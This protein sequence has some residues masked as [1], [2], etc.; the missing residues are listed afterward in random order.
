MEQQ[1]AEKPRTIEEAFSLLEK[2]S[3]VEINTL[4]AI[5]ILQNTQ[6]MPF[7]VQFNIPTP[8]ISVITP[9]PQT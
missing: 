4:D 7:I 3:P 5:R 8:G 1:I 2:G 9:Q 6:D